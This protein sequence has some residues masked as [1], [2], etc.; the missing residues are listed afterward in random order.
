M[1]KRNPVSEKMKVSAQ[2]SAAPVLD[3]NDKL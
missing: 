2:P 1:D 3:K